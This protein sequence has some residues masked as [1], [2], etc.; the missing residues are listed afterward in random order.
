MVILSNGAFTIMQIYHQESFYFN[1]ETIKDLSVLCDLLEYI[2]KINQSFTTVI[3][4][5]QELKR[6]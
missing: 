1:E 5:S 6:F 4:F 3:C 2:C